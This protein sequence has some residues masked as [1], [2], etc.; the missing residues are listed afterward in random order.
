M[1]LRRMLSR[2]SQAPSDN[3]VV[4]IDPAPTADAG[5][6]T[7]SVCAGGSFTAAATATNGGSI[8]WTHTG[9]GSF[10]DATIEDAVYNPSAADITSG[11]VT[12][13]MTVTG[14]GAC[15][16]QAPS[17]NIVVTIDPAPTADAGP[18]T[19]SVC[20]GGSFTAAATA[21]NGGSIAWTHTG[22]GSFTDATI[23]DA[24]YNPRDR[25]SVV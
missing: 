15:L 10:T 11:S 3:I 14:T 7:G 22:T 19:G 13:T 16:S 23:E 25:K 17:D 24:V 9:T 18:A 2:S 21:T 6:A 4:T 5:P 1:E 8:A 12:L 20:A